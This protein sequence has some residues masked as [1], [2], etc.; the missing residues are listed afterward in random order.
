MKKTILYILETA[1]ILTLTYF[2]FD[3]MVIPVTING[4]SMENTLQDG[5]LALI[6]GMNLNEEDIDLFDI[7]VAYSSA[8]NENI[9]KRVIGLPGDHVSMVNDKLYIND[10]EITETYLDEE[11]IEES[12][13]R[14]NASTF[15][16]D[17]DITLKD[18]EYFLLGDNRLNSTDSRT[19]GPFSLEDIIGVGGIVIYPFDSIKEARDALRIWLTQYPIEEFKLYRIREQK[20]TTFKEEIPLIIERKPTSGSFKSRGDNLWYH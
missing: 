4:S 17:F 15:T 18:N 9:I 5:N 20:G 7:V 14:Y 11:F 12:K 6:N 2:V 3:R 13:L 16:D 8:L 10:V 1:I 19:L